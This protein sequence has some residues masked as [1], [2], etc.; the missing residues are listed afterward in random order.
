MFK[1]GLVQIPTVCRAVFSVS[2][3][4]INQFIEG[5]RL[6]YLGNS[7]ASVLYNLRIT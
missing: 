3:T 5:R 7:M 1:L 4:T 2:G 6:S